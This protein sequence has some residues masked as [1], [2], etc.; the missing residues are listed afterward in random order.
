MNS[1]YLRYNS[2]SLLGIHLI[3]LINLYI[4]RFLD[5]IQL[6]TSLNTHGIRRLY[7][8]C[9][10]YTC[11]MGKPQPGGPCASRE[12]GYDLLIPIPECNKYK[13]KDLEP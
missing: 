3:N 9:L 7:V 4:L 6:P 8:I 2:N 10:V 11:A 13:L 12:K 5:L 1:Y